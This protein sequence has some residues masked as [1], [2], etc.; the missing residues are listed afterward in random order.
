[1]ASVKSSFLDKVLGR[2]GRLDTEGLQSVVQRL[3]RE[4]IGHGLHHFGVPV[5]DVE[6]AEP[7]QA[8]EEFAAVHVAERVEARV[9]PLHGGIER[10]VGGS[11]RVRSR[12]R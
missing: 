9:A 3:A 10:A 12:V 11:S 4:L 2:I 1:M 8:I 6:D 7:A 5:T